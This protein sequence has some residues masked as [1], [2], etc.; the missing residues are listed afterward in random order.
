MK[1]LF[2]HAAKVQEKMTPEEMKERADFDY[3]GFRDED[4]GQ[5][6]SYEKARDDMEKEKF[7]NNG[8]ESFVD[9][10]PF[11]NIP[12]QK[13]IE[14]WLVAKRRNALEAKFLQAPSL[15]QINNV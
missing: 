9:F 8:M 11:P 4:D 7:K 15:D 5:L 14:E 6:L 3:F 13:E 2:E 1:E 12:G 10:I